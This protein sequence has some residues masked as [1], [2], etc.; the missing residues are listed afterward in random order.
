MEDTTM[1]IQ[2]LL[3][4]QRPQTLGEEI[5]NSISHGIGFLLAVAALPIL[6]N[7]CAQRGGQTLDFVALSV[8]ASTMMLLYLVSAVYHALPIGRLKAVFN[9]FDHAAIY[10]FIAGSYTPFALGALRG[11]LGW[12]LFG[13][14]WAL[15]TLGVL[16]KLLNKLS[17]PLLSTGL[18]IAMGWLAVFA[19]GPL[20]ERVSP[21]GLAML[22]AGGVAYTLGAIVFLFDSRLRYA[23]FVWHLFVMAGSTCHFFAALWYAR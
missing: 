5:A 11:G 19:A 21:T 22:L 17:H 2:R 14:V 8:F 4:E 20:L 3:A 12:T 7:S 10:V 1:R 18:Y 13:V 9:R 23:H 6:L 16:A 15:A